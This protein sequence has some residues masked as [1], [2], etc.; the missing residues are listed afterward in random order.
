MQL[1]S[2]LDVVDDNDRQGRGWVG[3]DEDHLSPGRS[4]GDDHG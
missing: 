3:R 4:S 1:R 2:A